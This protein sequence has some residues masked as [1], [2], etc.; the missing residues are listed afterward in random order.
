MGVGPLN[1]AM[2]FLAKVLLQL[3]YH[4]EMILQKLYK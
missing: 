1:G 3:I 2:L 4:H